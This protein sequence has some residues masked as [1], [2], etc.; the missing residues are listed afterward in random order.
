MKKHALKIAC[1]SVLLVATG[2]LLSASLPQVP[3]GTWVAVGAMN[4]ARAGASTVLLQDG[5]ILIT[6]GNDANGPSS[7]AEFFGAN[8]S[9]SLATPMNFHRSEHVSVVLQD[10]RV[11]V[12]G[13]STNGGGVT[14]SAEIFDPAANSWTNVTGGMLEARAGQTAT[15]LSDGRVLL[16]G[17]SGSG[18]TTSMTAEIFDPASQSF[19]LAG[20]LS[21][22]RFNHAAALL[23]DGRVLIVG[24]SDG[25][26]VLATSDIYDPTAGTISAG[27]KLSAA[28]HA[29]SGTTLLDGRGSPVDLASAEILDA[30]ATA[31]SPAASALLTARS[32]QLAFLLPHNNSVLIVGGTSNGT[33]LASAEL[34]IPWGGTSQAGIFQATGL[35]STARSNATGSALQQDGMLL[36]AGGKDANGT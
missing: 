31:F 9:F 7:A 29:L 36:V 22:A 28:R 24:G 6:G 15:L 33:A 4:S 34:Y 10:G 16:A 23:Q 5:R 11:L 26:K 8:G 25:T 1:I 2:I 3:S 17:G 20:V 35:M 27:P 14:N 21:S 19:A 12:A 13:G 32:G 30:G 18:A